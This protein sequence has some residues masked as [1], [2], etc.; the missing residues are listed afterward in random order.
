[1]IATRFAAL[2]RRYYG[3]SVRLVSWLGIAF[4]RLLL[5]WTVVLG[6]IC[7]LKVAFPVV[8]PTGLRS[9]AETVLPYMLILT[10]PFA[11]WWAADRLFPHG[12]VYAQPEIRLAR[13]GRW[14][15]IDVLTAHTHRAFGAGGF[16]ASLIVGM[17]LNVPVRT[18]EFMAA[19]PAMNSNAP[20]WGQMIFGGMAIDLAL[21]NFL[22]VLCFFAALRRVPWFPRL[23]LLTWGIDLCGQLILAQ[24]LAAAPG[25]PPA[26]AGGIG[27]VL[28]GNM[29]AI[30]ISM[31]VWLP[32]LLMSERVNV[33]YRQRQSALA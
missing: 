25:L 19:V 24:Y 11:G 14:H 4:P 18:A 3:R 10:S 12:L 31:M 6:A 28:S 7:M 32:Y 22:Y 1:M 23:L 17:M 15:T 29:K 27:T 20:L 8:A 16:M 30:L 26:V 33:T 5:G 13:V 2:R 9:F 21:M